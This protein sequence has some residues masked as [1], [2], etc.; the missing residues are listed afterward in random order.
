MRKFLIASVVGVL[1]GVII[2]PHLAG[3]LLAEETDQAK[4][5]Q[6]LELF[7]NL[8]D[9]IRAKYVEEI[10]DEKLIEAALD[11]MLTSLD[12]H[13]SYLSPEDAADR[14]PPERPSGDHGRSVQE[15]K[16]NKINNAFPT[17]KQGRVHG[18]G[19]TVTKR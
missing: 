9:R 2:T 17:Y 10:D 18:Q 6:Q 16:R 11:G 15:Q 8:F 3:P 19:V 1:F 14:L 12:P 5:Y 13:S 4:T 7:G